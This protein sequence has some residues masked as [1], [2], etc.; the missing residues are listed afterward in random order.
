MP[1]WLRN[2]TFKFIEEWYVKQDKENQK[3]QD[4]KDQVTVISKDGKV[5][6]P[7]FLKGAK[8]K[9]SYK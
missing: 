6:A 1:I 5:Q 8:G 4:S 2:T 9:T 7:D 3:T